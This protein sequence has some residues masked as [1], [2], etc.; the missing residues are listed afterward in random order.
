[1]TNP[2]NQA[3]IAIEKKRHNIVCFYCKFKGKSIKDYIHEKLDNDPELQKFKQRVQELV[4]RYD[5]HEDDAERSK[6]N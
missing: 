3:W 6:G 4:F 1:M 5:E 2:Q